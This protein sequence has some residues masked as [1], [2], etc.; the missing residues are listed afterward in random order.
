MKPS[1]SL[2]AFA[3][4]ALLA[5]TAGATVTV[6][7]NKPENFTDMPLTAYDRETTLKSLQQH[8]EKLGSWLPAGQ[9]FK[10]EVIDVDLAGRI[11]PSVRAPMDLRVLTGGADWPSIKLRYSIE[12]N[13][14][15]VKSGEAVVSDMN[16]LYHANRYFDGE[17]LR[18]EKQ[19]LDDW[20]KRNIQVAR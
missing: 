13:G 10:V 9:D 14:A 11:K 8:F 1:F 15:V 16:Y 4:C 7:F 20:F 18:Y 12:A 17:A 3:V 5:S 19:M 2:L 6:S